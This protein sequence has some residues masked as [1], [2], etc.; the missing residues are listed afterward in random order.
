MIPDVTSW[1]HLV[2][3]E[4][5]IMSDLQVTKEVRL[6]KITF[7]LSVHT[8]ESDSWQLR[9]TEGGGLARGA[10]VVPF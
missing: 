6:T 1:L 10:I 7:I 4:L 2:M 3:L 8:G 9:K 5:N